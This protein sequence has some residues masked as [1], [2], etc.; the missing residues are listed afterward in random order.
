MTCCRDLVGVCFC[1]CH[2]LTSHCRLFTNCVCFFLS[3]ISV[4]LTS[5]CRRGGV[6]HPCMHL[7]MSRTFTWRCTG[8]LSA[9]T[10]WPR[11]SRL[12]LPMT[13]TASGRRG[14]GSEWTPLSLVREAR[15]NRGGQADR[16]KDS[17]RPAGQTDRYSRTE[18]ELEREENERENLRVIRE[19][20]KAA[21]VGVW[22]ID[23]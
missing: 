15:T 9:A 10:S 3:A 17:R 21:G 6:G 12:W 8:A 16:Q 2:R 22:Y 5:V 18:G 7:S 23:K 20:M 13:T 1:C 19:S 11:L 4:S 14:L